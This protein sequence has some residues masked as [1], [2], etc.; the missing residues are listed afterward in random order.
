MPTPPSKNPHW[1]AYIRTVWK[2]SWAL[3]LPLSALFLLWLNNLQAQYRDFGIRYPGILQEE[4]RLLQMGKMEF[5]HIIRKYELMM[6]SQDDPRNRG[7][8]QIF[9]FLP[10][11]NEERLNS[12]LPYSGRNYVEA[13]LLYP[14]GG[15]Y[16]VEVKYR[17]DFIWHWAFYKK[18]L[19]IKT[20]KK[21]LFEGMRAFNLIAPKN[22]S[23]INNAL[24]YKL[25]GMM[26]LLAPRSDMANLW[27]NGKN[28]GVFLLVE[29]ISESTLRQNARMP[30]D[31]YSGELVARDRY[32][33][34]VNNVFHH[35]RL[36][37]KVAVNNHYP[38]DSYRPIEKFT[39]LLSTPRQG[40]IS[41]P[42]GGELARL[43]APDTWGRFF[44]FETLTQSY[45]YDN[46]HNWRLYYDPARS[47]FEPMVWD[48]NSWH[49]LWLPASGQE[50]QPDILTSHLHEALLSTPEFLLARQ[51]AISDFFTSGTDRRFLEEAQQ[52]IKLSSYDVDRDPN[53]VR[54]FA[55]FEPA[56]AKREMNKLHTIIG[57]LF[58]DIRSAYLEKTLPIEYADLNG[59]SS[60]VQVSVA[61]RQPPVALRF[62]YESPP[63]G[64]IRVQLNQEQQN[65]VT[66]V[67]VSNLASIRGN[68]VFVELPLLANFSPDRMTSKRRLRFKLSPARY[69][70]HLEG[71][72]PDNRLLDLYTF[73]GND[74]PQRGNRTT[75][76]VDIT[77]TYALTPQPVL[78][79]EVWQG[80]VTIKEARL[81]TRDL[82]IR[83]GTTISFMEHASLILEGRLLA[84]GTADQPI[85]FASATANQS[86]WGA[87]ILRGEKANGSTIRHCEFSSGSGYKSDLFEYSAMLS[88]HDVSEVLIEGCFFHDSQI[89][90]DMVH[91]VY[92]EVTFRNSRFENA[93][94]D[95]LDVDIGKSIL[96]GC[97]FRNSGNDALDL[98]SSRVV[99][100]NSRI[101]GSQDKGISVGEGTVLFAVNN[102]VSG[103]QVG[104][105]SKDRSHAHLYNVTL[106]NNDVALDAYPKNWRY[107]VGGTISGYY[108]A[109]GGGGNAVT[110]G[111]RSHISLNR[112]TV[113]GDIADSKRVK[114]SSGR[115]GKLPTPAFA[116]DFTTMINKDT[117]G[118]VEVEN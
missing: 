73:F 82:I 28:R 26:G 106:R 27:I 102:Y 24:G 92:S 52:L 72:S 66:G 18:S 107:G 9:L 36:W 46:A 118:W 90:D 34:I 80:Q 12:H 33:G 44:A 35:P 55:H 71:I 69:N 115:V 112:S 25:A 81:V 5:D 40:K 116:K 110:I 114:V 49:T 96:D 103:N 42:A 29:Q 2:W 3:T 93:A 23:L 117:R 101:H 59:N 61:G 105:Q 67:D 4:G 1:L 38:V 7:L 53:L 108:L 56:I 30:G 16:N 97:T 95:A 98:M 41:P 50:A 113:R 85:K 68:S 6:A 43:L 104:V 39:E 64:P 11:A 89:V 94:F 17:G 57:E 74:V 83:P 65:Q 13:R 78:S 47:T 22:T 8:K 87:V 20:K 91:T 84:D 100:A 48:P 79:P 88:I 109:I 19:R 10:E 111:K 99:V 14:D 51:K 75:P 45:H 77:N 21:R 15:V 32:R 63:A 70:F 86:P 62:D 31:L 60:K 54:H 58:D 76:Q 37:N